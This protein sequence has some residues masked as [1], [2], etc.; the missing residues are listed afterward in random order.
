MS[1]VSICV[2]C[3]KLKGSIMRFTS[4]LNVVRC[5]EQ[6]RSGSIKAQWWVS[7][8]SMSK[9]YQGKLCK[10]EVSSRGLRLTLDS[11]KAVSWRMNKTQAL[12][13]FASYYHPVATPMLPLATLR[14]CAEATIAYQTPVVAS[15]D[16]VAFV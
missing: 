10:L 14:E 3:L 16:C 5:V 13:C 7:D 11:G 4:S 15:P 6:L 12:A 8:G 9:L 2:S 1:I